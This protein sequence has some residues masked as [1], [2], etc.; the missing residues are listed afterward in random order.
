MDFLDEYIHLEKLCND[1]YGTNHGISKYIE[2]METTSYVIQNKIPLWD[3]TYKKLKELRWKRNQFV[4]EG[5]IEFDGED[6]KWLT[7]FYQKIINGEDP[8]S[9]RRSL[10]TKPT[11]N[12]NLSKDY[13]V[14]ENSLKPVSTKESSTGWIWCIVVINVLII[15]GIFVAISFL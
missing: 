4:H 10:V 7:A 5:N 14:V 1:I 2:D 8:L 6:I 12:R 13:S 9:M 15:I 11:H 3:S